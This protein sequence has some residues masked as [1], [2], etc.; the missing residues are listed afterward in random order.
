MFIVNVLAALNGTLS[1][2]EGQV[3]EEAYV[4]QD[5]GEFLRRRKIGRPKAKS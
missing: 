2:L 4:L 1:P 5:V 3:G